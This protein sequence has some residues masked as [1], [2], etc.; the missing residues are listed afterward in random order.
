MRAPFASHNHQQ[1]RRTA[2]NQSSRQHSNVVSGSLQNYKIMLRHPTPHPRTCGKSQASGTCR[3]TRRWTPAS[4]SRP[5]GFRPAAAPTASHT[6][7]ASGEG[8]LDLSVSLPGIKQSPVI[9]KR[10]KAGRGSTRRSLK[11][12]QGTSPLRAGFKGIGHEAGNSAP[13]A[14]GRRRRRWPRRKR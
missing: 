10:L 7:S 11:V 3:R 13:P 14:S 4:A 9:G 2:L 12:K 8:P 1:H 6:V 5:E